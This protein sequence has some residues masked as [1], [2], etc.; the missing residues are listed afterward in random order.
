ME[1][2]LF[3]YAS[4]V[5]GNMATV[6]SVVVNLTATTSRFEKAFGG[7][8]RIAQNFVKHTKRISRDL[9]EITR[10]SKKAAIAL[11][12]LGY[13]TNK[14]VKAAANHEEAMLRVKAITRAN[15]QGPRSLRC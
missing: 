6:A 8:S 10:F 11:T 1:Y 15:V 5:V 13:A 14:V 3:V 12:G 2:A 9:D 4:K 7:A